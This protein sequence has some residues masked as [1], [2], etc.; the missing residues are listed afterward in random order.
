MAIDIE[1]IG[2]GHLTMEMTGF[3]SALV[4]RVGFT[5]CARNKKLTSV[6]QS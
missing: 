2:Q 3:R 4:C 5:Q 6:L 1:I